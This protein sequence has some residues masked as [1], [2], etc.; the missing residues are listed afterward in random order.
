[1]QIGSIAKRNTIERH[2]VLAVLKPAQAHRL[3]FTHS[4]TVRILGINARL[5]ADD[6][7]DAGKRNNI[8]AQKAGLNF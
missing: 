5:K 8:V 4:G 1:M 2:V 6:V 3:R 7:V